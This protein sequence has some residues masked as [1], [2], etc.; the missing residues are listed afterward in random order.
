MAQIPVFNTPTIKNERTPGAYQNAQINGDMVGLNINAAT[1][2]VGKGFLMLQRGLQDFKDSI[3]RAKTIEI[4]TQLEKYNQNVL[5]DKDNGYFYQTGK[6]AMGKSSQIMDDYDKYSKELLEKSKLFGASATRA[7]SVIEQNRANVFKTVNAHDFQQTQNWQNEVYTDKQASILNKVIIERNN[8]KNIQSL[9]KDGMTVLDLQ[10][11]LQKWDD[12]TVGIKRKEFISNVHTSVITGLLADGSLSAKNYF[13]TYKDQISPDKHLSLI[14]A[15]DANEKRYKAQ[16][17]VKELTNLPT[18]DAYKKIDSIENIELQDVVRSGYETKAREKDRLQREEQAQ[19]EQESWDN[20]YNKL[21][22]DPEHAE[23][24]IDLTQRPE[25]I[26]AQMSYIEKMKK[27]GSI[28]TAHED[29]MELMEQSTYNAQY[30]KTM[31]LNIYRPY[32]SESDFKMFKQ[33]Q[34]DI[35][36]GDYSKIKDDD[37]T[38]NAAFE[39]MGLNNRILPFTGNNRD[40]AF[41]EVRSMVRE[42]ENRRGR[43]IL[44]SELEEIIQSLGYKDPASKK[45]TYKLIEEGMRTKAGFIKEVMNDFVYFQKKHKRLPSDEEKY[46]IINRRVT[47]TK[48]KENTDTL[49]TIQNTI[50]L[51]NE[52]KQ[53]TWYVDNHLKE[54]GNSHGVKYT[55]VNGG[56]Y[57]E[58]NGKYTSY[59]SS[60]LAADVSMSEHS[61]ISKQRFFEDEL[62]NPY[63]KAIGT[64][65]PYILARYGSNKKIVDER[66]FDKKH[67]T[68]HKNHAHITLVSSL[69]YPEG[70][71]I[72]NPKTGQK[73]VMKGG[74]W[75]Q[76]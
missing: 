69:G 42:Y 20:I 62:N 61:N 52:T 53:L 31:D 44:D 8:P 72:K 49:K 33:R 57:R 48:Q 12:E 32:L 41:N 26:S 59:H 68:N 9:I 74:K 39:A 75:Q 50:P 7:K 37:E 17:I 60:G 18:A 70:T 27:F 11:G 65:D 24:A 25:A 56:R 15:V 28:A 5:Y 64:S 54:L 1:E 38:I 22:I 21:Q 71:V 46:K 23:Q 30:F 13:N 47:L 16:S 58:P 76:I 36:K 45:Q 29:Y 55:V 19:R 10:A 4:S 35:I 34:D 73:M 3:D 43:K 6:N 66:E 14:N 2:N 51:K 40:I 67:G 63:V